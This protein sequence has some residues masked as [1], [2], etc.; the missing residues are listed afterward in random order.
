[1]QNIIDIKAKPVLPRVKADT[2]FKVQLAELR[3]HG[4]L[5]LEDA[6]APDLLVRLQEELDPWFDK[7]P[8]GEGP[9]FG[10]KTRRF[11]GILA[12]SESAQ[13]LAIH[14]TILSLAEVVLMADDIGPSRCTAIQLNLTQAVGIEPNEPAQI[15]HRDQQLYPITA[16]FELMINV[17][18]CID[19]FSEANGSTRFVPGSCNWSLDRWPLPDEVVSSEAKA[20]SAIIWL[21]SMMHGGGA[22]LSGQMRRGLITSYNLGWLQQT[23]RLL[24]S[25]PPEEVRKMPTRLQRLIGY[26]VHQPNVGWVEGRDPLE[27]LMGQTNQVGSAQ[28]H[29]PADQAALVAAYYENPSAFMEAVHGA[30]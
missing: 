5:I 27:W 10:R 2:D 1:M 11:G 24:L 25:V 29:L 22:N 7:A 3:Q 23:E 18:W 30:T 15:V 17:M 28:D 13:E 21:G 26:Q 19:D 20:G 16:D 4:V 6:I 14:P 8:Y 9:F 12:K